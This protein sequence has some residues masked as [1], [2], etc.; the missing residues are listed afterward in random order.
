MKWK[1]GDSN[2]ME[3]GLAFD[4]PVTNRRDVLENRLTFDWIIRY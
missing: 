2:N 4:V 3:L 1:P